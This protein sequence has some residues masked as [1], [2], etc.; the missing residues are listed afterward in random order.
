M[1]T[2]ALAGVTE[3]IKVGDLVRF[4]GSKVRKVKDSTG[5]QTFAVQ[6]ISKD[7]GPCTVKPGA[8]S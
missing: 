7:F 4:H 6:K 5:D 1:K 3:N 8:G 2:Y